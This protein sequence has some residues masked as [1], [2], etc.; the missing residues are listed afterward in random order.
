MNWRGVNKINLMR[1]GGKE[2]MYVKDR[3]KPIFPLFVAWICYKLKMLIPIVDFV[4]PPPKF[5]A[6][7]TRA[8]QRMT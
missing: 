1:V 6:K 7:L 5:L 8:M 4:P 3:F 2:C